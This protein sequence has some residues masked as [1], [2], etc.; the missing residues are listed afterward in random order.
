MAV[1]F[2][3][4]NPAISFTP[5]GFS[6]TF[7]MFQVSGCPILRAVFGREGWERYTPRIAMPAGLRRYQ[8]TRNFHFIAFSCYRHQP[9]LEKTGG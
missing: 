9:F 8:Q 5:N 7:D 6:L 4:K 3:K 2:N 1:V